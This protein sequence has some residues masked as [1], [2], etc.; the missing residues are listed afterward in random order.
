MTATD[1]LWADARAGDR[2]AKLAL[3]DAVEDDNLAYA[4]RWCGA[5]QKWPLL[6][7]RTE[8]V[9]LRDPWT[10]FRGGRIAIAPGASRLRG[11]NPSAVLPGLV[12]DIRIPRERGI[13]AAW[14]GWTAFRREMDA[15]LWLARRL[16]VGRDVFEAKW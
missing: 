3:A 10:W 11:R 16:R 12:Y 15:L 2:A 14:H 8:G 5:K 7:T 13:G 1:A 4:V 6:R 9:D